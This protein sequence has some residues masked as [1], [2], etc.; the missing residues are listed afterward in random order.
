MQSADEEF[1]L[2]ASQGHQLAAAT[3]VP[4]ESIGVAPNLALALWPIPA[5]IIIMCPART[6]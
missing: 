2:V 1:S 5:V 6:T 4:H 3:M